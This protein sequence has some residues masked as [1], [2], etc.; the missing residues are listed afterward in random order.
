MNSAVYTIIVTYNAMLWIDRCLVSLRRSTVPSIPIVVDNASVDGTVEYIC[1][2]YPEVVLLPQKINL[3]FG[4]ANNVGFCYA[5]EHKADYVLLLNQDAALDSN[6]LDEMLKQSDGISLISPVH[7]NGMGDRFDANFK[8]NTILK[9]K[10]TFIDD[11]FLGRKDSKYLTGEVCAACW[12]M[13]V[14]MLRIIGGFN[15]LFHHYGED[16]NYYCRMEYF[17]IKTYIV[18]SALMFHDREEYGN[19]NVYRK[20]WLFRQ[21]LYVFANINLGFGE[22]CIAVGRLWKIYTISSF[23]NRQYIPFYFLFNLCL[24]VSQYKKIYHSRK[25]ERVKDNFVWL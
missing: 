2:N 11:L 10:N 9:A 18:P 8:K 23:R 4:Q 20:K 19:V 15:P 22:I 17:G 13:P 5:L 7:L 1:K 6:A 16:D 12:L 3:G 24:I 25:V 14:S 21:M